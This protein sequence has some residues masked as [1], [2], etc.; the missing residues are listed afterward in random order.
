ME[1]SLPSVSA[2][3]SSFC[4]VRAAQT[5]GLLCGQFLGEDQVGE[6]AVFA[7]DALVPSADIAGGLSHAL[8]HAC[9]S[10]PDTSL[11]T[12]RKSFREVL[13]HSKRLKYTRAASMKVSKPT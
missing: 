7:V 1:V 12:C 11:S 6:L 3:V 4:H 8:A 10:R 2:K 13:P 5:C 9:M